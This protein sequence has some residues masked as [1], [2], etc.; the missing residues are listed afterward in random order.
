MD[1]LRSGAILA[2]TCSLLSLL[3]SSLLLLYLL[4]M[5][6][7]GVVSAGWM[8]VCFWTLL[9]V[10][11]CLSRRVRCM[12]ILF[13][14]SCFM[15]QSR[16]LLLMAGISFVALRNIQ[17]TLENLTGLVRSMICNLKAKRL[18]ISFTPLD[19]YIKMLKWVFKIIGGMKDFWLTKVESKF[20]VSAKADSVKFKEKLADVQQ[21]LNQTVNNALAAVHTMRSVTRQLLPAVSFLL[22]L[23][24]IALHVKKYRDCVRYKN[25][26]I[27][28]AFVTFDAKEKAEGRPHVLPLTPTEGRTHLAA[29]E[30]FNVPLTMKYTEIPGQTD[31]W[32]QTDDFSYKMT[33]FE[34]KCLPQPQLLVY[35]SI[36]PLAF[37]LVFLIVLAATASKLTQLRLLVCERFFAAAAEERVKYL[38]A[39]ILRRR[40]EAKRNTDDDV[41][42]GSFVFKLHF[43]CP[44]IFRPKQNTSEDFVLA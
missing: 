40:H 2:V 24:F 31:L 39:K 1:G 27:S 38:H 4:F 41:A 10:A 25:R 35:S 28:R 7:Y 6:G 17:N 15:K 8:A 43:W 12:G 33:L 14:I 13:I 32:Q 37:I 22:L 21:N 34:K 3:L 42:L 9:T 30:P 29:L 26:F 36:A 5:L 16:K 20:D 18:S 11:F 44:L 23:L 19:N